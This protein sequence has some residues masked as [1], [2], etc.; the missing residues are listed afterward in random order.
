MRVP[1]PANIKLRGGSRSSQ[2]HRVNQLPDD[3]VRSLAAGVLAESLFHGITL[4]GEAFERAWARAVGGKIETSP[5]TLVDVRVGETAWSCKTTQ[6]KKLSGTVRVIV[7]RCD[8][9]YSMGEEY[10]GASAIGRAVLQI[11]NERVDVAQEGCRSLRT[12][13]LLRDE[14]NKRYGIYERSLSHVEDS[15]Y[16][17]GYNDRGNLEGKSLITGEHE[18]TWQPGGAQLT[19]LDQVPSS[20]V[21]FS[22]LGDIPRMGI[23]DVLAQ[24]G[25][26]DSWI[27]ISR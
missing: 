4:S 17:W 25:Y 20:F 15:D 11:Y 2:V 21:V 16:E 19:L 12:V 14:Q 3:I 8:P 7:G 26:R 24:I 5:A 18:W 27:T 9:R 23:D 1:D 22:V 13:V 6:H 10:I